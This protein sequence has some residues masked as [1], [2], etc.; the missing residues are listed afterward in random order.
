MILEKIVA[1]KKEELTRLKAD[2]PVKGLIQGLKMRIKQLPPTRDFA[3]AVK[4]KGIKIIAEVK[5]ASPSKGVIRKDFKPVEIA[6]IYEAN[7]AAAISVLTEEKHFHG[8]IDYLREIKDAVSLPILRK[9]FIFD[10]YQIY[11]SRAAGADAILLIAAILEK[12]EIDNFLYLSSSLA[13]DCV[14]EVHNED[15]LKKVL[16]TNAKLIGINNRDLKTFKADIKNTLNLITK[17]PKGR[18]IISES[19]INSYHD[20]DMLKRAGAHI[21]LVGE[22]VMREKDMGRKLRE[23]RGIG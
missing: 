22:A 4:G 10:E 9:D 17:V 3:K 19:G 15:E 21:F 11:E 20:I 5:K 1:N 2:F 14:V 18:V 6:R 12:E 16:S 7:G 13:M 8:H 23:L